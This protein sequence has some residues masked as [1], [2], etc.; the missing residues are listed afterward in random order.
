M[1][2]KSIKIQNQNYFFTKKK[3]ETLTHQAFWIF[4]AAYK[5]R[6]GVDLLDFQKKFRSKFYPNRQTPHNEEIKK[7]QHYQDVQINRIVQN[8]L[9]QIFPNVEIV[10]KEKFTNFN[11]K[12][13][14]YIRFK[15]YNYK[16]ASE[17]T[18]HKEFL[19]SELIKMS[20]LTNTSI[21]KNIKANKH[22][23]KKYNL[24]DVRI[25]G[26]GLT[27]NFSEKNIQKW[28]EGEVRIPPPL[29]LLVMCSAHKWVEANKE[30]LSRGR[31][32]KMKSINTFEFAQFI[33]GT[34]KILELGEFPLFNSQIIFTLFETLS[35]ITDIDRA[36]KY[37]LSDEDTADAIW[38]LYG[39]ELSYNPKTN[40]ED[41]FTKDDLLIEVIKKQSTNQV[42]KVELKK[43][44]IP[45]GKDMLETANTL[46]AVFGIDLNEVAK[47]GVVAEKRHELFGKLI[48]TNFDHV[49]NL[50]KIYNKIYSEFRLVEKNRPY[51]KATKEEPK[52][53]EQ[54]QENVIQ[55]NEENKFNDP[56]DFYGI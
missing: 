26:D 2:Q 16:H 15:T 28:K 33:V 3:K 49:T 45:E 11:K 17:R 39:K 5:N 18:S 34:S 31:P 23:I 6:N 32:R 54:I 42:L 50:L 43:L 9:P 46:M 7:L 52:K 14:S 35:W 8:S 4:A 22:L 48:N 24:R 12:F 29:L 55:E 1:S 51:E 21:A 37:G 19:N 56:E 40:K 25:K 47:S 20:G 44:G 30:K 41:H 38:N 36:I 27:P 13:R 53:N 10:K